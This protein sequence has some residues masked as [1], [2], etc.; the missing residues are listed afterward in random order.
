MSVKPRVRAHRF[1]VGAF[2]CA[3]FS[4]GSFAYPHPASLFFANA[5]QT[6]LDAALADTGLNAA[7]WDEYVS[8]YSALLVDTGAQ[9]VLVDTGGGGFAPTNG[10]LLDN[11]RAEGV[12][13]AAIDT[14][15]LTHGHADHIGG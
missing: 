11:L 6:A 13:L 5:P 1:T 8:P 2:A 12:D 7:D 15:V 9:Q 14:V 3:I 4:D 10:Q